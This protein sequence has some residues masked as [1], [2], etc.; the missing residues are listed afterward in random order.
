MLMAWAELARWRN[1]NCSTS[2]EQ[3]FIRTKLKFASDGEVQQRRI[4]LISQTESDAAKQI[5]NFES[6]IIS[7]AS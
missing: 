6:F 3:R 7:A 1:D 4:K 5:Y 2:I